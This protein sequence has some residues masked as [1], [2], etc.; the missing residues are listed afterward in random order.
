MHKF[1][2]NPGAFLRAVHLMIKSALFAAIVFA[3]TNQL[4]HGGSAT[5]K[6][7][8]G[9]SDWNTATNWTPETVPNGSSDTATFG[10]SN[11]TIV[12]FSAQFTTEVNSIVFTP[13][14]SAFTIT[15][16]DSLS[17]LTISG[18]GVINNSGI[19][20]QFGNNT[21]VQSVPFMIEGAA[22]IGE[23]TTF[24]QSFYFQPSSSAGSGNFVLQSHR[25]LLISL[26]TLRQATGLL[27]S[28]RSSFSITVQPRAMPLSRSTVIRIMCL[29]VP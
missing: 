18:S 22:T 19:V 8:P 6:T 2:S 29:V 4:A 11:V 16:V 15:P 7:N 27:M 20:Q 17:H 25:L 1:L 12:T 13:G 3:L 26:M 24:N 21:H 5:W 23:L 9:S 28:V 10:V 14:A